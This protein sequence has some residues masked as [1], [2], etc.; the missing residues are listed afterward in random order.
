MPFFKDR[1]NGNDTLVADVVPAVRPPKN[2]K[3]YS[4]RIF[5]LLCVDQLHDPNPYWRV[6]ITRAIQH[7]EPEIWLHNKTV[8]YKL[9]RLGNSR[10]YE[11]YNY[12]NIRSKKL[13]TLDESIKKV[14][15]SLPQNS[16]PL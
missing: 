8:A 15:D 9:R 7:G 14:N 10:E 4:N 6:E 1:K 11:V 2:L 13:S 16:F 3:E 5:D 12:Q